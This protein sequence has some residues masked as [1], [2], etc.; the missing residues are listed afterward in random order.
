MSFLQRF[1]AGTKS[2]VR[3]LGVWQVAGRPRVVVSSSRGFASAREKL[4]AVM[5]EYRKKNYPQELPS[6]FAKEVTA[7][8]DTDGDGFI[9]VAEIEQ[10]LENIGAKNVLTHEEIAELMDEVGSLEVPK[11]VPVEDAVALLKQVAK[12]G[13]A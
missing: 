13:T 12:P 2:H 8:A 7:A 6:R 3:S 4:Q 9:S 11:G 5:E 1:A 10:L